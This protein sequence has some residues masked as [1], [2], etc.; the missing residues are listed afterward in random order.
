M[1]GGPLS[2]KCTF[3]CNVSEDIPFAGWTGLRS[4]VSAFVPLN[5]KGVGVPCFPPKQ[6]CQHLHFIAVATKRFSKKKIIFKRWLKP[7]DRTS[8]RTQKN[9]SW[10]GTGGDLGCLRSLLVCQ[11]SM[12]FH[13]GDLTWRVRSSTRM[14]LLKRRQLLELPGFLN[15]S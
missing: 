5:V 10:W 3:L 9:E 8:N 2:K 14:I 12:I 4:A 13:V 7:L 11:I 15:T 6:L 1:S